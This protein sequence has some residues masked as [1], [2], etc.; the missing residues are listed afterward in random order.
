MAEVL[1]L[2]GNHYF[3]KKLAEL[4][5][6][7]GHSLTL[8]NRGNRDDGLGDRIKR[9]HCDRND[10]AVF[11]SKINKS[12]DIVFDNCCY[13]Y[14]QAKGACEVF[15]GKVQKYIFTSSLSVY[16]LEADLG[17]DQFMA[18][19]HE[20][21]KFEDAW[22]DYAEAK[23]QAE[24][25][26]SEYAQFPVTSVRFP[27]VLD[28]KDATKRLQWHVK[29]IAEEEPIYFDN[30]EARMSFISADDAAKS[31]AALGSSE[32]E[33]SINVA[34][35]KPIKLKELVETIEKV[36]GKS[37]HLSDEKSEERLSPYNI[38]SD[39]YMNCEKL[40]SHGIM[41]PSIKSYL[42]KMIAEIASYKN[43]GL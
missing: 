25:A 30:L 34:S 7:D 20:I 1:L 2:G 40:G 11:K 43:Y 39:W 36:T 24:L 29:K 31:L 5:L 21:E 15:A 16:E 42:P 23:R 28:S 12:Y 33:G 19:G 38:P 13:D 32:L 17:E 3:G 4:L 35:P 9:I 8:V 41:L 6:D 22:S 18:S 14:H 37:I 27:I 26:F 10:L